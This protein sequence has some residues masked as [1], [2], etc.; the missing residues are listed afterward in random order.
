MA[1][2]KGTS[3]LKMVGTDTT[4]FIPKVPPPASMTKDGRKV[5]K[6]LIE[7]IPNENIIPSDFPVMEAYCE[8]VVALRRATQKVNLEGAVIENESSVSMNPNATWMDKCSSKVAAL[9]AKLRLSPSARVDKSLTK[10]KPSESIQTSP[11]GKLI[12][13]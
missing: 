2:S 11:M 13:G 12:H 6:D 10:G 5:W 1:K 3:G 4:V 9:S 8:A 7:L